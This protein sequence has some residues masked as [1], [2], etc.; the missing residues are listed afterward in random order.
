MQLIFIFCALFFALGAVAASFVGVLVDRINTGGSYVRGRSHCDSCGIVLTGLDLI[1][2]LSYLIHSGRCRNCKS[3]ISA[4]STLAELALGALYILGYLALGFSLQLL[5]LLVI[6]TTLLAIVRYDLRHLIIPPPF[7]WILFFLSI[8]F[9]LSSSYPI[10]PTL[11][12]ALGIGI[13]FAL[14]HLFS[15]G[16][17][18]GLADSPLAFSLA[19][20]TG[21][22]ALSGLFYSF[23]IGAAYGIVVLLRSPAGHR[24]GREVPFAPFLAAGFLLAYFTQWNLFQL[25]AA[26]AY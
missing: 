12:M 4:S 23:W 18:M 22:L 1:P 15:R 21:P 9:A 26:L 17:A 19:L 7:L 11:L 16:R 13:F 6:L 25:I 2:V 14:M 20:M 24:M 8:V 10:A 3:R 5:I